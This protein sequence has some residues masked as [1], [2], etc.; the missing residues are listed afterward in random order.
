[1]RAVTRNKKTSVGAVF[2]IISI[3]LLYIIRDVP[4]MVGGGRHWPPL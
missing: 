3:I 1:M 2:A 4:A